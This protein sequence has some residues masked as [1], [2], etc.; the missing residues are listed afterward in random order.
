MLGDHHLWRKTY[1]YEGSARVPLLLRLPEDSEL[2]R[3]QVIDRPVGLEDLAPTVLDA[4]DLPVPD[5]VEGR[6][7]LELLA[8]PDREDWREFYHGEHGPIYDEENACQYLVGDRYKFVWNPITDDELLFDLI[9]DPGETTDLT[10]DPD[11]EDEVAAWRRRLAE[12]LSGRPEEFVADGELRTKEPG[13]FGDSRF[14]VR[15][16]Y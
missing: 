10:A 11:Y 1:A 9:A 5:T 4:L 15:T 7:L 6:S 16:D 3:G 8:A 13:I 12:A 2:P 14:R